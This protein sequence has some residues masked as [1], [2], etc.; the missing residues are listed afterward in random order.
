MNGD[1]THPGEELVFKDMLQSS[2]SVTVSDPHGIETLVPTIRSGLSFSA[3]FVVSDEIGIFSV[4]SKDDVLGKFAVNISKEESR[5]V[6]GKEDMIHNFLTNHGIQASNITT[7]AKL[8][9]LQ[10]IVT[11]TRHGIEL[12]KY[13]LI[14]A[15]LI[16][17]VELFI[18]RTHRQELETW[19]K[20]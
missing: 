4:K 8:S 18:A 13:F 16:G 7:V 17:I 2:G 1:A 9:D 6:R 15:L 5:L 12:W 20:S 11:Q 3:K 10:R 19:T 14:A